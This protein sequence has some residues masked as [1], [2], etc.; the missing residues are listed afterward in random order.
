[1]GKISS[2]SQNHC[3]TELQLQICLKGALA[4]YTIIVYTAFV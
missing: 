1:M 2:L 4:S 3:C